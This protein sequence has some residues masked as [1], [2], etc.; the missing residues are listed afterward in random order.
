MLVW[1]RIVNYS[2]QQ[3]YNFCSLPVTPTTL[4]TTAA[5]VATSSE[6]LNDD[7]GTPTA[8]TGTPT[9]VIRTP[10]SVTGRVSDPDLDPYRIG[11]EF[12]LPE[13]QK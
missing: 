1:S 12:N 6:T 2:N 13:G 4:P 9:A 8:V 7:P 10:T 5:A 3:S 11:S